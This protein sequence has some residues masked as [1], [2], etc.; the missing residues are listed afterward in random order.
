MGGPRRHR[1][2]NREQL[3]FLHEVEDV[4][5]LLMGGWVASRPLE[6]RILLSMG[7][8]LEHIKQRVI[9]TGYTRFD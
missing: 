8:H 6:H 2:K 9:E 3:K 7:A 1:R 5:A 4:L